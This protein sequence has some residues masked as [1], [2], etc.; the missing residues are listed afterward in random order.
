ML[1]E[2]CQVRQ[3]VLREGVLHSWEKLK[4][5]KSIYSG[6]RLDPYHT[7]LLIPIDS[8]WSFHRRVAPFI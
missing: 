1:A 7:S 5:Y 8:G 2:A 4:Q 3:G 6:L